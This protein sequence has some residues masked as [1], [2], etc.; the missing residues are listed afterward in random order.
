[1]TGPE[2]Y[3]IPISSFFGNKFRGENVT[4]EI[5][6]GTD[7]RPYRFDWTR[8][9]RHPDFEVFRGQMPREKRDLRDNLGDGKKKVTELAGNDWRLETLPFGLEKETR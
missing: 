7:S 4:L 2:K 5:S 3:D 8:K 9:V 6:W 1:M